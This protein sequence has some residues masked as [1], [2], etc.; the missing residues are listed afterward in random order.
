MSGNLLLDQKILA[1]AQALEAAEHPYAF[2]GALALAYYAAPRGTED[3]D[4]NLFVTHDKAAAALATL[5]G[6]GIVESPSPPDQD[7]NQPNL[8]WAHTPIHVFLSYDP[9]HDSCRERVRRV[10]F[11]E[12]EISILS[13]EDLAVFKTIYDRE[14]DRIDVREI[15]LSM[16]ERFDRAYVRMWL[17][18]LLGE[19]DDRV[20]RFGTAIT[21]S[22]S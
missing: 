14:K 4:L 21:G 20:V 10:P 17:G 11:A 15:L 22:E 19:N 7:P 13:G 2:G 18:R 1:I 8:H 16:G 9:F 5:A 12:S 3:I 6:L